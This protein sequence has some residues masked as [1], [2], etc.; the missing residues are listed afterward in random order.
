[1]YLVLIALL[2]LSPEWTRGMNTWNK[3][4]RTI[5]IQFLQNWTNFSE[6]LQKCTSKELIEIKLD[7]P[8]QILTAIAF[9][10]ASLWPSVGIEPDSPDSRPFGFMQQCFLKAGH[11]PCR[12]WPGLPKVPLPRSVISRLWLGRD[13]T[14]SPRASPLVP[15]G[16]QIKHNSNS[17]WPAVYK[18][19]IYLK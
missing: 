18:S 6:F 9:Q 12:T 7:T 16:S 10:T 11:L 19:V 14:T 15:F 5:N 8:F 13:S 3:V 1:M 2:A 4:L 17:V